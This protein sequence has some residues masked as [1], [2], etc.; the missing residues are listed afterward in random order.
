MNEL[1]GI[2]LESLVYVGATEVEKKWPV[3]I[4]FVEF[5]P[6]SGKNKTLQVNKIEYLTIINP[7][8]SQNFP[9]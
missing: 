6:C 1:E 8:S 4:C 7:L 5:H 3:Q 2:K 9:R